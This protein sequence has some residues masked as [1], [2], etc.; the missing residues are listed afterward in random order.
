M[1]FIVAADEIPD[2]PWDGFFETD[3]E[4][5]CEQNCEPIS[6]FC[7]AVRWPVLSPYHARRVA[8]TESLTME[9][10]FHPP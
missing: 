9:A 2:P 5:N 7:Q 6:D 10:V 1:D 8:N 4:Q 3:C